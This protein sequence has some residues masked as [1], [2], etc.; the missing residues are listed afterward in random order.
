MEPHDSM[1]LMF[2]EMRAHRH[3]QLAAWLA[4]AREAHSARPF[5]AVVTDMSTYIG[6]DLSAAFNVPRASVYPLVMTLSGSHLPD[7]PPLGTGWGRVMGL[8]ERALA[9]FLKAVVPLVLN[10]MV[11]DANALREAHG[12]ADVLN[13][14]VR[15]LGGM[16]DVVLAP[17]I[18]GYDVPIAVAPNVR[19]LGILEPLQRV[20]DAA[21]G[22][23]LG[24][25]FDRPECAL[26]TVYVNFG[27]LAV[28]SPQTFAAIAA[29]LLRLAVEQRACVVWKVA[30]GAQLQTAESDV[31]ARAPHPERIVVRTRFPATRPIYKRARVF[32][33]H[34]GD[35]SLGEAVAAGIPIAGLAIFAD[36]PDVCQRLAERGLG[37][38][39]GPRDS[40]SVDDVVA[41]VAPL[42]RDGD[43]RD[44]ALAALRET[45]DIALWL[46]GAEEGARVVEE[47][48]RRSFGKLLA[49]IPLAQVEGEIPVAS[50]GV[51]ALRHFLNL[52]L[53]LVL[54][55]ALWHS[56]AVLAFFAALR[57]LV[58]KIF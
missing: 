48:V 29:G 2:D 41:R 1:Q 15:D 12:I 6:A 55:S 36:Q 33:S 46:G 53:D 8:G 28:L 4:A 20:E 54:A 16:N 52:Q 10:P 38:V 13:L 14:D 19:P 18:W 3:T 56:C 44:A 39:L 22:A 51:F 58:R 25:L 32:V 21:L 27:T 30:P 47:S 7:V 11:A 34:C 37:V 9:M 23:D 17:T 45:R 31:V 49:S 26:N 57:A 43:A 24:E 50:A 5:D 40:V 42:L 35:T